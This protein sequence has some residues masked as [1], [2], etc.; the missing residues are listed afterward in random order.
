MV[1]EMKNI[2]KFQ[3]FFNTAISTQ[4]EQKQRISFFVGLFLHL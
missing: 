4:V 2:F 1:A 3:A